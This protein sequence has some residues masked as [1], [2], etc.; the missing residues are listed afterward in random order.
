M[1][2]PPEIVS[3]SDPIGRL[4]VVPEVVERE[5]TRVRV[6]VGERLVEL[7]VRQD[8]E[9]RAED[10][11]LHAEHLVGRVEHERRGDLARRRV[12]RLGRRVELDD[13]GAP[14]LRVVDVRAQTRVVLVVDDR[15]VVRVLLERGEELRDRRLASL[16]ERVPRSRRQ[17]HVVRR[18]ARLAGVVRLAGH[19]ALGRDAAC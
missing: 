4:A 15:R 8:R 9:H 17:H 18:D 14:L 2:T 16:D 13:L 5:R 3:V 12:E 11:L 6:H 1:V 19:D 7:R 10:L